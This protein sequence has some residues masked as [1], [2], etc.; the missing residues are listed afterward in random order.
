M[1][2]VKISIIT[3][4]LVLCMVFI[5]NYA[6]FADISKLW[7]NTLLGSVNDIYMSD[8]DQ[9]GSLEI[10]VGTENG[11]EVVTENGLSLWNKT[12]AS[13]I[14]RVCAA[15]FNG[16]GVK[17]VVAGTDSGELGKIYTYDINGNLLWSFQ[18]GAKG[19]S[20]YWPDNKLNVRVIVAGDVD[21]DGKEEIV[22][23]SNHQWFPC[24]I[25]V[26]GE[27]GNLEG[28]YWHPGWVG[29]STLPRGIQISDVDNDGDMEIAMGFVNNDYGYEAG[30]ALFNGNNIHG[31]APS[32]ANGLNFGAGSQIW[33]WHSN[34]NYTG[35]HFVNIFDINN[36]GYKEIIVG[37]PGSG[38]GHIYTF[39]YKGNLLWS[40]AGQF[41]SGLTTDIDGDS[42]GEVICGTTNGVIYCLSSEGLLNWTY[43]TSGENVSIPFAG[44]I[45]G[46]GLGEVIAV[47]DKIYTLSYDGSLEYEYPKGGLVVVDPQSNTI[48]LGKE[49]TLTLLDYSG[50]CTNIFYQDSDGDGYGDPNYWIQECTI[51]QGYVDNADD[52]DDNDPNSYPGAPEICD[53]W[54][55]NDCDGLIDEPDCSIASRTIRIV[56]TQGSPGQ[57]G[58]VVPIEV[59]GA[60]GI[61]GVDIV[62]SYAPD[63]LIAKE[64]RQG[65]LIDGFLI[66]SNIDP[67]KGKI[68]IAIASSTGIEKN[69][70]TLV[71]IIFDV[72]GSASI[73]P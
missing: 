15:D 30:V 71:E 20:G 41:S 1:K 53:D 72:S 63:V 14:F 10:I 2:G 55:D 9:D 31:E 21:D 40:Y 67:N 6:A 28:E 34:I 45:N 22:T 36:D 25:C 32:N 69:S 17:E 24:R 57:T 4:T 60:A 68:N 8:L 5:S 38:G 3:I 43:T 70:G 52:C 46:D 48:L 65:S 51:S 39:D 11:L 42:Y 19:P 62:L 64:V 33:Y 27:G 12:T 26:L 66:V 58:V 18:T 61:A 37:T 35:L 47:S 29:F 56:D 23:G 7:E 44:D 59:E 73:G 50:P 54:K 13:G 49:N 16:D